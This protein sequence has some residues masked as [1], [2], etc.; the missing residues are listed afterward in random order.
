MLDNSKKGVDL[1]AHCCAVDSTLS[2]TIEL[3]LE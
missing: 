2:I 3:G 1:R